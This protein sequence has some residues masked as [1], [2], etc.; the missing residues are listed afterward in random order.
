MKITPKGNFVLVQAVPLSEIFGTKIITPMLTQ[1]DAEHV[2]RV[3]A[4]GEGRWTST[5]D[6]IPISVNVGDEIIIF[7]NSQVPIMRL[8]SP[9]YGSGDNMA[10]LEAGHIAGVV[11]RTGDSPIGKP[12][13]VKATM[14]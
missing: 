10:L 1:L 12:Q 7:D 3:V 6:L 13:L 11:D 9:V 4:V 5:G 14:N 8:P 2:W